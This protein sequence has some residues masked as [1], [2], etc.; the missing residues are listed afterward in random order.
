MRRVIALLARQGLTPHGWED[1]YS[2]ETG[3]PIPRADMEGAEVVSQA[4]YNIW[5][6][7]FAMRAYQYANLGYKVSH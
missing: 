4:W 5:E 1:A 2:M 6:S 7:G 3:Y